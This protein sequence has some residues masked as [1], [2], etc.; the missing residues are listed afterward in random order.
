MKTPVDWVQVDAE[1]T[2]YF[3][4]SA[5]DTRG[6]TFWYINLAVDCTYHYGPRVSVSSLANGNLCKEVTWSHDAFSLTNLIPSKRG[7]LTVDAGVTLSHNSE[8]KSA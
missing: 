8:V 2:Y 4:L 3:L 6:S 1:S 7:I 5:I